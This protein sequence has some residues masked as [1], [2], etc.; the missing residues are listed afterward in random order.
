MLHIVVNLEVVVRRLD[1]LLD[2]VVLVLERLRRPALLVALL[3][4]F[5]PDSR[6]PLLNQVL[7]VPE[8]PLEIGDFISVEHVL[9]PVGQPGERNQIE[10]SLCSLFIVVVQT[11][12]SCCV[13][14]FEVFFDVPLQQQ[15]CV[16]L[17]AL[18]FQVIVPNE[19]LLLE[20]YKL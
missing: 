2:V 12:G 14:L 20:N 10:V 17:L 6:A 5:Y 1:L 9:L 16:Q 13:Q 19:L 18:V 7:C 3:D 15:S 4:A 11:P 8:Q